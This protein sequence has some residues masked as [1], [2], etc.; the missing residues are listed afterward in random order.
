MPWTSTE[1]VWDILP[2]SI[3]D[4]R[5]LCGGSAIECRRGLVVNYTRPSVV[6]AER[7]DVTGFW[8]RSVTFFICLLARQAMVETGGRVNKAVAAVA[9]LRLRAVAVRQISRLVREVS[10]ICRQ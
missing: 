4:V 10:C 1:Q 8:R 3:I 2:I 7:A 6:V 5:S 9:L